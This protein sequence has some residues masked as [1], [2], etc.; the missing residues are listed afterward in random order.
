M[1]TDADALRPVRLSARDRWSRTAVVGSV[2]ISCLSIIGVVALVTGH[3]DGATIG[4]I[5]AGISGCVGAVSGRGGV[6]GG[7]P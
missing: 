5:V 7:A 6:P 4:A 2:G 1:V 3:G